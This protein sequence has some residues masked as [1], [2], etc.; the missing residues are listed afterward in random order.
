M[1]IPLDRSDRNALLAPLRVYDPEGN[2]S[3]E[4]VAAVDTGAGAVLIPRKVAR[5]L[6]YR[7]DDAEEQRF[8]AGTGIFFAPRITLGRVDVGQASETG[9]EAICYD[10][11]QESGLGALIGLTFLTRF[12]VAFDFDAWEMELQPRA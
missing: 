11:P 3:L 1:R 5:R 9:V 2:F 12:N 6:G 8:V 7:I 10:L 4:L